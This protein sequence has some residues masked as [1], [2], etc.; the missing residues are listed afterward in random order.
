MISKDIFRFYTGWLRVCVLSVLV[1]LG[2]LA[3][4]DA[5]AATFYVAPASTLQQLSSVAATPGSLGFAVANSPSGSVVVLEDGVYDGAPAGFTIEQPGVTYRA[6]HWHGASIVNS[7]AFA[8][9]SPGTGVTNCTCQGMV[10]GPSRLPKNDA[11]MN[12]CWTGGG[13]TGWKFFDCKF[14]HVSGVGFGEDG[15]VEHCLF[16]DAYYN[17]FDVNGC[18]GF[19]MRNSMM[20]RSNRANYWPDNTVGNKCDFT[21]NITF[22]GLV[23]YDNVGEGLWFDTHNLNYTVKNCTFFAN[24]A[25]Y[26]WN[27]TI[28][29]A[30][31]DNE[32]DGAC[33]FVT[34]AN[35]DG[36]GS[37]VD[38]V[39]YSNEWAGIFYHDSG[40]AD[41]VAITIRGNKFYDSPIVLNA[42]GAGDGNQYRHYGNGKITDNLFV[43]GAPQ[44]KAPFVFGDSQTMAWWTRNGNFALPPSVQGMVFD[45]NTY[46]PM[47]G[48]TTAW[49]KYGGDDSSATPIFV[50][51]LSDLQAPPLLLEKNGK[52]AAAPT[53]RGPLVPVYFWPPASFTP[54]QCEFPNNNY[55]TTGSI[56]QVND[57]ETPY[58]ERAVA[59]KR[60][61]QKVILTV[62]GHCAF[63]GSG[64]YACDV[65]DYSGRYLT[66]ELRDSAARNALD[67]AVPGYA[68]LKPYKITV[69]L[70]S[71]GEYGLTAV[72]PAED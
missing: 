31:S 18:S 14:T 45:G 33:G 16:T 28:A 34:E 68:V 5:N 19:T 15:F 3:M 6:Q 42:Q 53:L 39:F 52:T 9:W 37:I 29:D 66:L 36:N 70:L 46:C 20:R 13:G 24:H 35:G 7:T 47:P 8:L 2:L 58:I 32:H 64:P 38:N 69:R 1:S 60:A 11:E 72:Y 43:F 4:H 26:T 41:G 57:D 25:G 30:H 10:F 54:Q 12:N 50:H 44:A 56:H 62:F 21:T 23:S 40:G 65:Y 59:G 49:V 61:G 17:G 27:N 71:A 55:A 22:D 51:S 48:A 67:A 63:T